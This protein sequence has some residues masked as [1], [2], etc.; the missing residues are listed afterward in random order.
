MTPARPRA[1]F[2]KTAHLT[3]SGA[4]LA[5]C[6]MGMWPASASAAAPAIRAAAQAINN[7]YGQSAATV[8]A[9]IAA[10]V[11][12][13]P[14]VKA[15]RASLTTLTAKATAA[16]KAEAAARTALAAA[17]KANNAAAIAANTKIVA[18][19]AAATK[20]AVA[21]QSAQAAKTSSLVTSWTAKFRAQHYRPVDGTY[22]GKTAQYFIPGIGLEPIAV[23]I[24]VY[25]G[26]VSD[27]S[28]PVYVSTGDSGQY[29]AYALPKLKSE[30][31][32]AND[33]AKIASVS[34]ATLTS[35]AYKTSLQNALTLAGFKA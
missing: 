21:A 35:G 5:G 23:R 26:H 12:A 22:T 29:N 30:T 2:A 1:E 7:D 20:T 11:T 8:N 32:A 16:K 4:A 19:L 17:K 6:V 27:V 18:T 13:V 34:G 14:A 31:M 9:E 15:A 10:Q 33:T 25:R 24:T 28:V 3:I